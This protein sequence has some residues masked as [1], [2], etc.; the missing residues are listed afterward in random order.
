MSDQVVAAIK[1]LLVTPAPASLGPQTRAGVLSEA[2]LNA[3]LTPL[4]RQSEVS[5][6]RQELIRSLLLLWH[7]HLDASHT[8]SQGIEN[9]DGSF[10]HAIMHRREP[11]YWNAKYWWRRVGAHPVFPELARQ[12]KGVLEHQGAGELAT[13]IL[14]GGKWS[15]E[16]F[17]D[18]CEQAENDVRLTGLLRDVQQTETEVLLDFLLRS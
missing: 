14:P 9:V 5:T 16:A 12:V 7:D 6:T 3:K 1:E 8:I 18:C 17:V 2:D 10:V 11:D 4:L 15:A 13:R